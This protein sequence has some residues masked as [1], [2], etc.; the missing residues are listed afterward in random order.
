MTLIDVYDIAERND[1]I[2]LS[3]DMDGLES[4]SVMARN[5]KCGIAVDPF[6]LTSE[7]DEKMKLVHELGHCVQG[8]FYN[9]YSPLDIKSRH[10]ARAERWAIR[11]LIPYEKLL[12]IVGQ[13]YTEYWELAEYFDVPCEFMCRAIEYYKDI[14]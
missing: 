1:I 2:V 6:L 3:Y 8:A 12:E 11:R 14:I 10:E 5:G 4:A 7:Q 9:P 13:G